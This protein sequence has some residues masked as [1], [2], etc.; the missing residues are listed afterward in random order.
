MENVRKRTEMQLVS[1]DRRL[2]KLINRPTFKH[3]IRYNEN[4]SAV[5]LDKKIITFDKP[6][7][8]GFAVLEVSKT[9]MFD[10][11]YNV[12]KKHYSDSIK[13]MYTDTGKMYKTYFNFN[14][15]IYFL[16]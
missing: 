2:Q 1:D 9:L 7:Y 5:A 10:Y 12:M 3:A 8:I 13:L 11:H 16:I 14:I 6:L 15:Y 4:L